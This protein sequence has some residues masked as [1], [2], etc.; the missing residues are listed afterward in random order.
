MPEIDFFYEYEFRVELFVHRRAAH[1]AGCES[2]GR[3][4]CAAAVPARPDLKAQ[5]WGHL[6]VQPLS[7]QGRY[8]VRDCERMR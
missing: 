2:R 5:G 6:A 3:D 1:R 4:G 7:R 8:M